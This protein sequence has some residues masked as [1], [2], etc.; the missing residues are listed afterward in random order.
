M[1][2]LTLLPLPRLSKRQQQVLKL[3]PFSTNKTT[4][5]T[6][7]LAHSQLCELA[8]LLRK[9]GY[10]TARC[11]KLPGYRHCQHYT[12]TDAGCHILGKPGPTPVV[13]L[14]TRTLI[15]AVGTD[16]TPEAEALLWLAVE[17]Q[18]THT[19]P[20]AQRLKQELQTRRQQRQTVPSNPPTAA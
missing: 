9:R 7:G 17:A 13:E 4:A 3:A 19:L 20:T 12:L 8:R 14:H 16:L 18:Q 11:V 5:E 1:P 10:L 15:S 6:A 2:H